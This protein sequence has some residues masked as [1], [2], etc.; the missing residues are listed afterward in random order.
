VVAERSAR[1]RELIAAKNLVFRRSFV[2][3]EL[4][5]VT[6]HTPLGENARALTDNFLEVRLDTLLPANQSVRVQIG[7]L[8]DGSLIGYVEIDG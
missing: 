3:R 7:G 1:L 8:D 5:A 4:P 2:G 6:L